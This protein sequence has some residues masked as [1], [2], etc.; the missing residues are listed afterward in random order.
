MIQVGCC[1]CSKNTGLFVNDLPQLNTL[2]YYLV[3]S[4][5][6]GKNITQ[7][8]GQTGQSSYSGSCWTYEEAGACWQ[9]GSGAGT[10]IITHSSSSFW[11]HKDKLMF[12]ALDLQNF[13]NTC[14]L[15]VGRQLSYLKTLYPITIEMNYDIYFHVIF[16]T[17]T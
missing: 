5:T 13:F 6:K 1:S 8:P 16:F 2:A 7:T 15:F 3:A 4:V 14:L 11:L 17:L 12:K 10:S 9:L